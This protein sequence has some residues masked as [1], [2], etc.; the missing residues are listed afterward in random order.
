MRRAAAIPLAALGLAC[1]HLLGLPAALPDCPG[2]LLA[3]Q[4]LPGDFLR[5]EAVRM[6]GDRIDVALE[7]AVQRRG[8]ALVL[9]GFSPLGIR[10]FTV[11][12]QG[13]ATTVDAPFGRAL[14]VPP[15][16]VLRDLHRVRF[17]AAG[18]PPPGE[19]TSTRV[20]GAT[21]IRERWREG[22]LLARRFE[23][24]SG[25]GSGGVEL[26][27]EPGGASAGRPRVELRNEDCGYQAT[28]VALWEERLP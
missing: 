17:L 7:L 14:P 10:L 2:E 22:T 20:V 9:V 28:W 1:R 8:D 6:R 26:R 3:T 23:S 12:Q 4:A 16:N 5:R 13:L 15:L 19:E 25:G 24:A 18:E 11:T 21:A 27:F